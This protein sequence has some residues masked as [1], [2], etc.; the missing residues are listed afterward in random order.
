LLFDGWF[1]RFEALPDGGRLLEC[2][3]QGRPAWA[4]GLWGSA[5]SLAAAAVFARLRRPGVVLAVDEAQALELTEELR[6]FL[7]GF[8]SLSH[9]GQQARFQ[10]KY[11]TVLD[12]GEDPLVY[13]PALEFAAYDALT[14]DY[15]RTVERMLVLKRLAAGEPLLLVT[16]L[17]AACQRLPPPDALARAVFSVELERDYSLEQL[18]GRLAAMG[19]RR[20]FTVEEPGQFSLRGGLLD[21]SPPD[22]DWP[23]RLEF[24][25]DR[26]ASLRYFDPAS[27]RSQRR[28]EKVEIIPFQE[29]LLDPETRAAG[30]RRVLESRL[31]AVPRQAWYDR[32]ADE[33]QFLGL[34]WLQPFFHPGCTLFDYLACLPGRPI[35]MADQPQLMLDR[36]DQAHARAAELLE[37]RASA[38]LLFPRPDQLLLG[39]GGLVKALQGPA[40]FYSSLLPHSL[41]ELKEAEP[42]SFSF[43]SHDLA[44]GDVE[45]F[46]REVLVWLSKGFETLVASRTH[47]ELLR[48]KEVLQAQKYKSLEISEAAPPESI[49]E[50][51]VGLALARLERGF[52][53]PELGISLLSD[54][55]LFKRQALAAPRVYRH[56]YKGLK[57]SR[58]I[59]SFSELKEGQAAV[60]VDHGIGIFRGVVRMDI[61]GH[62][63]DFVC[64]EYAEGEKLYVPT[65][66][67]NLVQKYLG[68]D[69]APRL[70]KLGGERWASAR[71]KV[72]KAVAELA[73]EL[74]Q[75]Y[76]RRQVART[77]GFGADTD[78]Q[79]L[80]EESFPYEETPD[81]LK[82][83][84]AVKRDMERP[85]PMDRLVCGDVGFGKTEVALRAAFKAV[86]AG[87]QVALLAPTTIL[88]HQHFNTFRE[89][90]ADWPVRMVMLSRFRSPKQ[91]KEALKELA[92]GRADLAI[93]THRLLQ[94]DVAF[95]RLGLV[96][97]DEEQRFGVAHKER[98][99]KLR[100]QVA[101]IS[102][103]ATPIPRTLHFSLAG[104][105][106]MSV[107]ET[108]PLDRLPVRTY[109]LEDNQELSRQAIL[110]E[111]KRGG[112]VFFVHNR[113]KDI[114]KVAERLRALV[115]E[116]RVA[117]AHGQMQ[118][119][120][121]EQVMVEFL[122]RMHDVLISTT[123]IESG[124]D[125]PNV[126]T[127]IINHAEDFG[128]SQL[129]QL[130]GR[131]G[132]SER[133]AYAYLF[134]PKGR[135]IPEVAEKRL[136]AIEEFTDLGAGFKVAMRD[137]EIRGAGNI[138]GAQ[139]HGQ[140][141]AVGF[142]LYCHM[143]NE[144]VQRL[145]GE[146]VKE[147]RN[148]ALQLDLD[149]YL[150]EDYVGDPRMKLD[151]YKRLAQLEGEEELKAV[152]E[153][154]RD[155]FGEPPSPARW[156]FEAV[157]IR[158]GAKALGFSE[159]VQKGSQVIFRFYPDFQPSSDF[160]PRILGAFP[161][162]VRFLAGP[163]PGLAFTAPEGGG[164][165]FLKRLLPQL[166]PYVNI[167]RKELARQG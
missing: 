123:I 132:R 9:P 21:V 23:L 130:R 64:L 139:Q 129:Y 127:I 67:V 50:G 71:A 36:L 17:E 47:G 95:K 117:V 100:S 135:S 51:G 55:E 43:K 11:P 40:T 59:E 18:A 118:K 3:R 2:L 31:A 15:G 107:I 112:Q 89:R 149:A 72:K 49:P 126:N 10:V 52:V 29:I 97:I 30:L 61:D 20:E 137:L 69:D 119:D 41:P 63:K 75:L 12:P 143:L 83:I 33:T 25:G 60:H 53:A 163:P 115:P 66:Q 125:M 37:A 103:S 150:P 34:E 65:E 96:I 164:Y 109:V 134:Y 86:M 110:Q 148:P 121:L 94:R 108:P 77:H 90:M 68:G 104:L 7:Q 1:Q 42:L 22:H 80:F 141:A 140:V 56:R 161:G 48:M 70:H 79:R 111:L 147:D 145:K 158:L 101:V 27:Q 138:L 116:A 122:G 144:A 106:D 76:A 32:L 165:A 78:A 92:E 87:Q 98:L 105:R 146:E 151:L 8:P 155:R 120:E 128:L 5:R 114:H 136:S 44:Q 157:R 73:E 159:V 99:K 152:E 166:G 113:V 133:Q 131:V 62:A 88:A 85:K 124:L 82:A 39:R 81:Q 38:G 154:V 91:V 54:Q 57:G 16:S 156:L 142:D 13:F 93:G 26:L 35:L 19:Y 167:D 6:F 84:E 153:E 28:L 14:K 162:Q 74:L 102:M 4:S 24:D 58:P 46:G 45:Q 160:V